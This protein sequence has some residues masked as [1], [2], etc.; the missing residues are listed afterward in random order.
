LRYPEV[1]AQGNPHPKNARSFWASGAT[2]SEADPIC[3]GSPRR[4]RYLGAALSST[5]RSG[6]RITK[7]FHE[8]QARVLLRPIQTTL[9]LLEA[10]EPKP[11]KRGP[12]K[13]KV[14]A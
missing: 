6:C 4:R 3:I 13:K 5:R 7:A 12:Y 1:Q 2:I 10:A 14:T 11:G 9:A 8:A